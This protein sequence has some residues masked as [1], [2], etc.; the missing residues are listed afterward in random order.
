LHLQ[1]EIRRHRDEREIRSRQ[2]STVI[3]PTSYD[4]LSVF[5]REGR[6]T[7]FI[8]DITEKK[9]ISI[10][11]AL[12]NRYSQRLKLRDDLINIE[13]IVPK[14]VEPLLEQI[15]HLNQ[16]ILLKNYAKQLR[17]PTIKN[18]ATIV[19]MQALLDA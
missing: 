18:I 12:L 10:A 16:P 4:T 8:V 1:I 6:Y 11:L 15:N 2:H 17:N 13:V 5:R 19:N 7:I 3:I 9:K 14:A